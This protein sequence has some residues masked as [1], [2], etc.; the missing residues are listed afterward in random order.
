MQKVLGGEVGRELNS[1]EQ[2]RIAEAKRNA[3]QKK[4]DIKKPRHTVEVSSNDSSDNKKSRTK[5]AS[6]SVAPLAYGER[7][8]MD[9][10]C[11]D[12]EFGIKTPLQ[13]LVSKFSLFKQPKDLVN[14]YFVK[15]VLNEYYNQIEILVTSVR[16][17][18]PRNDSQH[19]LKLKKM[20]SYAYVVLDTL[21][22]WKIGVISSEIGKLQSHPRY[23]YVKEFAQMLR[24]I[25]RPIFI[26]EKLSLNPHIEDAFEALYR[27]L[28][29]EKPTKET[30]ALHPKI[31][32]ALAAFD[33]IRNNISRLLYPLLM[34]M[35]SSTYLPYDYFLLEN[36][37]KIFMFVGI[38]E[39]EQVHPPKKKAKDSVLLNMD[40][41]GNDAKSKEDESK[42][43]DEEDEEDEEEKKELEEEEKKRKEADNKAVVRG[44]DALM[45]L[46]PKSGLENLD[47]FPDLYPYF[48]EEL[49]LR[50]DSELISPKDPAQIALVI[51]SIIQ[52]LLFGFRSIVF[53]FDGRADPIT[54]I[55]DSWQ[56]TMEETFYINYLPHI[57]ECTKLFGGGKDSRKST[58]SMN[59]MNDI[60]WAR[61]YF[62]FPHYNYKSGIPPSFSKKNVPALYPIVRQ[63]R[64]VLT[65]IASDIEA[66]NQAGGEKEN[67]QCQYIKNPWDQFVFEI[68]NPL[69]KRLNLMLP[70]NQKTNVTLIFFTLAICTV[71]DNH[72]NNS[73]SIAYSANNNVIFRSINDLGSEPVLWVEK[74]TDT[75]NLFKQSI[76]KA[77]A[78]S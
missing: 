1:D 15:H 50:K 67:A 5:R 25:Y 38:S 40:E 61:Y 8:K 45:H 24:E 51:G 34:K 55:L 23:V 36:K 57:E 74:R 54:P 14:P 41:N 7:I 56:R 35:L 46:F 19:N 43:E 32:S 70:N 77:K 27:I 18:F 17:L 69:S 64:K 22:Q 72:L 75:F 4:P 20:S 73:S 31:S 76:G 44:V 47:S 28:F 3:S 58:Y 13:V 53:T 2:K 62:L 37:D 16:L 6:I 42:G 9:E 71:L 33:Y 29:I 21:R 78:K 52:E 12:K 63:L 66:A 49:N 48:A 59:L 68:A 10:I 11:G 30:E 65:E 39:S 26:L 60:Q